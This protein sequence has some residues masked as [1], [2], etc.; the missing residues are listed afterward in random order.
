MDLDLRGL[1]AVINK[2]LLYVL[3]VLVLTVSDVIRPAHEAVFSASLSAGC[4]STFRGQGCYDHDSVH[5]KITFRLLASPPLHT[6]HD[7]CCPFDAETCWRRPDVARGCDAT[8]L[9]PSAIAEMAR[10][11]GC[12]A[13][14]STLSSN[15]LDAYLPFTHP[16]PLFISIFSSFLLLTFQHG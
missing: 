13:L 5:D 6:F 7:D 2:C 14:P 10:Y 12:R 4:A 8:S 11:K 3:E 1:S 15:S 9:E 16:S